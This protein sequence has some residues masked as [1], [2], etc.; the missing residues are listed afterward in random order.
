MGCSLSQGI[1]GNETSGVFIQ[2]KLIKTKLY[3]NALVLFFDEIN[4]Y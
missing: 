3:E 1:S 2:K 4:F